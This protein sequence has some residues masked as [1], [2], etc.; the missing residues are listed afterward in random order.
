MTCFNTRAQKHRD[1]L[2]ATGW[3]RNVRDGFKRRTAASSLGEPHTTATHNNRKA[4][5]QAPVDDLLMH[6]RRV[7]T[8]QVAFRP[9]LQ[10]CAVRVGTSHP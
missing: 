3:S 6:L 9:A 8:R 1:P 4:G 10:M 5:L 7:I 2:L